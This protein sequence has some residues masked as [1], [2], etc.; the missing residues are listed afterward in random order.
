MANE[1]TLDVRGEICPYPMLKT[2]KQ[3]D[4]ITP[5]IE[6]LNVI[7]DH[8]PSL[9]TIPPQAVKRGYVCDIEEISQGEWKLHLVKE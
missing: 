3:L 1:E 4:E 8:P 9:M 2:N 6:I 5:D 7:T